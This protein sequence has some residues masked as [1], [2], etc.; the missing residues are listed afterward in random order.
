MTAATSLPQT[1]AMTVPLYRVAHT[2]TGDK[3][4]R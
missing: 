3:G 2:R 1:A 4:N